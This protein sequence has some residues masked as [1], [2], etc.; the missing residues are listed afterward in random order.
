VTE[1]NVYVM[2]E[3]ADFL[4]V[5]ALHTACTYY[6]LSALSASNCLSIYLHASLREDDKYIA[7]KALR[8]MMKNFKAVMEKEEFLHMPPETL[9]KVISSQFLNISHEGQLLEVW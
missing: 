4:Q 7:F 1:E 5:S 8:Y 6:L 2:M 3:M 9:L